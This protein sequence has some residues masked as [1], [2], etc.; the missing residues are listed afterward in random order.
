MND[1]LLSA[2]TA[3]YIKHTRQAMHYDVTMIRF[4]A[5][6]V[7]VENNMYYIF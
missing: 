3:N 2:E 5:T 1:G 7:A 4:S 6:I